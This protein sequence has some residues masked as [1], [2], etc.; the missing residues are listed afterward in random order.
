MPPRHLI[1]PSGG[2]D[3][4]VIY[5]IVQG[6]V[7]ASALDVSALETIH[8]VSVGAI[9]SVL[10]ALKHAPEVVSSYMVMRPW[11]K[12]FSI[13]MVDLPRILD[14]RGI[15]DAELIAEIVRPM[16]EA[17][18][19]STETTL[20]ALHAYTGVTIY[21]YTVDANRPDGPIGISHLSHPSLAIGEALMRSCCMPVVFTPVLRDE[22][23]YVDGAIMVKCP[24][25][26]CID[27]LG[28]EYDAESVL[29]I[30]GTPMIMTTVGCGSNMFEYIMHL[31]MTLNRRSIR[32]YECSTEGIPTIYYSN[33]DVDPWNWYMCIHSREKREEYVLRGREIAGVYA[34]R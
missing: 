4:L 9:I 29:V 5:G 27:A 18:G 31:I 23:C 22:S 19:L 34:R 20:Q 14:R 33:H 13:D 26:M 7:D 21:M 11:E 6:L 24:L 15:F 10:L 25:R 1:L 8:S 2:P 17:S 3:G 28:S 16:L 32:E 12:V 30:R